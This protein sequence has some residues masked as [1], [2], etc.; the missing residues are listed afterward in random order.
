MIL[1]T[2]PVDFDETIVDRFRELDHL[3]TQEELE[4]SKDNITVWVCDPKSKFVIDGEYFRLFPNLRVI[5]TPSTGTNHIRVGEA[6][7]MGIK[8][9]SLNDDKEALSEISASSEFAF[10][11]IISG[12]RMKWP[13]MELQGKDV[14][15]VGYGRIGK[16]LA[17][18]CKA[19]GAN[20]FWHDPYVPERGVS[21]ETIFTCNIVVICCAM[22]DETKYMIDIE[23]FQSL[24]K[25]A[26]LINVARGDIIVEQELIEFLKKRQDVRA[27]LDVISGE[28]KGTADPA[29]LARVGAIVSNHIAGETYDS[30]TKAAKIILELVR[31]EY[32]NGNIKKTTIT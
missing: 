29:S 23:Y 30:R 15:L 25:D 9:I 13:S 2:A 17:K 7:K 27:V 32:D 24:P 8:V 14:G 26:V 12:L 11:M 6:E 4:S 28:E 31:R 3:V 22:T 18:W 20:V 16:N 10:H 21:L 1:F 5:A 19:F